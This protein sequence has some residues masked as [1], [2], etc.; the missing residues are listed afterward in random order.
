MLHLVDGIV[1]TGEYAFQGG[2]KIDDD[3]VVGSDSDRESP[4]AAE[5]SQSKIFGRSS[6]Q[7]TLLIDTDSDDVCSITSLLSG[8]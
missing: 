7:D 5:A 1:A 2:V 4:T 3:D 8:N 6:S